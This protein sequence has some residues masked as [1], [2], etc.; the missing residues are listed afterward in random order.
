M[1]WNPLVPKDLFTGL[2]KSVIFGV[3]ISI[4]GCFEGLKTEGGAE[5]VGRATTR[6]V[7]MSFILIISADCFIT[8][9][10]YFIVV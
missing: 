10:F 2:F 5:G 1:T 3:I 7:V 6:S 8:A 9:L 4:I